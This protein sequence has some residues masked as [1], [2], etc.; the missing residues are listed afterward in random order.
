M[1][2]C[3]VLGRNLCGSGPVYQSKP[4]LD[5]ES[6]PIC[7]SKLK[8]DFKSNFYWLKLTDNRRIV[9]LCNPNCP[10]YLHYEQTP[11]PVLVNTM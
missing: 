4:K 10:I 9:F 7:K 6:E 3:W 5:F 11:K 2:I 8:I 1:F